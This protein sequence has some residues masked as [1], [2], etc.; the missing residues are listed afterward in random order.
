MKCLFVHDHIYLTQE[1]Q[2]YSNTFSYAILKRYIDT[3]GEVTVVARHREV[4]E[5]NMPEAGGK[6]VSFVFLESISSMGSYFGL[7]QGYQK[8]IGKLIEE[9]Q[10]LI[11]RLPS[12]FG[13]L[14]AS[15]AQRKRRPY[16]A[17]VVGCGWDAMWYYGGWRSKIYAPYFFW[18]MKSAVRRA[19]YVSYVTERFLQE[20]YPAGKDAKTLSI[21][22]IILP[23]T[24]SSVLT[25]RIEK[26]EKVKDR[27]VLGTI[28]NIDVKYKGIDIAIRA[29]GRLD[30]D[31]FEIEYRILGAGDPAPL[32]RLADRNECADS[33]YFDG[34]RSS[35]KPVQDWLD[36]VDIYLQPSYQEGLPRS[37]IEAM[38]RGCPAIG[39]SAGGIPELLDSDRIFPKG[40]DLQLAK[41]ISALFSDQRAMSVAA[42]D[43]FQ[44]AKRYRKDLIEPERQRFLAEFRSLLSR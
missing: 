1:G 7:R 21:S 20:R 30:R 2:V 31:H 34:V 18:K 35:G 13:L 38:S 33:I 39:S 14:A 29:V 15:T 3:F 42:V 8:K 27:I 44:R 11:I 40:D 22:D 32:M 17:E 19:G 26:I 4:K 24:N 43:N 12:E 37:L 25:K 41:K 6:G 23:N 28:A 9:H 36:T 5:S 10:A 16:L